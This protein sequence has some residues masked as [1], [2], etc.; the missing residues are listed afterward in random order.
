M[1]VNGDGY[2][3][4]I[5]TSS[6]DN[7][8]ATP[9]AVFYLGSASGLPTGDPGWPPPGVAPD[10][11]LDALE[12]AVSL[13]D[14]DGDG[15]DDF[16]ALAR[17]PNGRPFPSHVV[18]RGS[19][20]GPI[21]AQ[22]LGGV[23]G[24]SGRLNRLADMNGDGFPDLVAQDGSTFYFYF[25]SDTGFRPLSDGMG[26]LD[27]RLADAGDVDRDGFSDLVAGDE[28]HERVDVYRG[29]TDWTFSATGDVSVRQEA[30]PAGG[31]TWLDITLS[32][33]GPE[34]VR[35]RLVDHFPPGISPSWF[36]RFDSG[37]L[38][39]AACLN[40]QAGGDPHSTLGDIDSIV[41]MPPGGVIIYSATPSALLPCRSPTP[42]RSCPATG[43]STR[44]P[45][46][47]SP[48]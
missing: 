26:T 5:V 19:P 39:S 17:D 43:S 28:A 32:N 9:R 38:A 11:S 23:L 18:Y 10:F 33:A 31:E 45:P 34:T 29:G 20:S 2:D 25:G 22:E 4:L 14:L 41:T 7:E 37:P 24:V 13:G 15:H 21:L 12:N 44:T 42:R 30:F 46:T 40:D 16:V 48:R 6:D 8:G 35:V 36:C 27:A 3:D 1:D 47:T